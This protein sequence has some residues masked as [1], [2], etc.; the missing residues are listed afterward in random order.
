M[1]SLWSHVTVGKWRQ[2]G[3]LAWSGLDFALPS[4]HFAYELYHKVKVKYSSALRYVSIKFSS[5][6]VGNYLVGKL[7][8][9]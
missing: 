2:A 6:S 3:A 8:P 9:M 1:E 5:R 4:L 7:L